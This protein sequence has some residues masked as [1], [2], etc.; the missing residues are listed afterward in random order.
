M[1]NDDLS[2]VADALLALCEP[3]P[4]MPVFDEL[5][6]D[7]KMQAARKN[8]TRYVT[9]LAKKSTGADLLAS[10]L[11]DVLAQSTL[12]CRQ[13]EVFQL[14]LQGFTFEEIGGRGLHT[15]QAAQAVF[16]QALKKLARSYRVYRYEGLNEVYESERRR[17]TRPRPQR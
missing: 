15:K 13:M 9:D 17:G 12:T 7:R 1:I 11:A 6:M 5:G 2:F 3:D 10:E 8:D 16:V 14:R 4:D